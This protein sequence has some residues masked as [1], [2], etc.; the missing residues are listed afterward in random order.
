MRTLGLIGRYAVAL[1]LTGWLLLDVEFRSIDD[2]VQFSTFDTPEPEKENLSLS[3][4]VQ[5][6]P[7]ADSPWTLSNLLKRPIGIVRYPELPP[8]YFLK[9]GD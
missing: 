7:L 8:I 2:E 3:R 5:S 1:F 6:K 4:K 9:N